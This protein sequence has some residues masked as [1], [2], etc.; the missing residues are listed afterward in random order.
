M[1]KTALILGGTG[2]VGSHVVTQLNEDANYSKIIVLSRRKAFE[3]L[4]KV[5]VIITDFK[6]FSFISALPPI[7][8][9]FS[10]L[11]TTKKQT[12][13]KQA[14]LEIEIGIPTK[15]LSALEQAENRPSKIH[16]VST[17]GAN[18]KSGIFYIKMKGELEALIAE[19]FIPQ[20]FIYQPAVILGERERAY[21][22]W[23]KVVFSASKMMDKILK[24]QS[25]KYHT[26][27]SKQIAKAM[28]HYDQQ[29]STDA[30]SKLMYEQMTNFNLN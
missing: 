29:S 23:E 27:E 22:M 3:N 10:C 2:L 19:S 1:G 21:K 9:I 11:G 5:E 17:I 26:I 15:V 24:G 28:I 14:Y 18:A 7:D 25:M 12:P 13:N 16:V 30:I 4:K 8:S 6:D 20:K